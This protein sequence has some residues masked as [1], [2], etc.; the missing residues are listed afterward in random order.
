MSFR[1]PI[2][3]GVLL[4]ALVVSGSVALAQEQGQQGPTNQPMGNGMSNDRMQMMHQQMV[5][6]SQ[7]SDTTT[8]TMPGYDRVPGPRPRSPMR[9]GGQR[10][11]ELCLED[12]P[13]LYSAT[14][15]G[16]MILRLPNNSYPSGGRNG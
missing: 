12:S 3:L 2:Q 10:K 16:C 1:R 9:G 4:I 8:P 14:V 15:E 13:A 11:A 7:T 6:G 5:P